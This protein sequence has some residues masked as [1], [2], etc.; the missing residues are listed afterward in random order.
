M[1][2]VVGA[3]GSLGRRIVRGL[4]ERGEA[5]RALVR[6][7]AAR[8]LFDREGARPVVGDLRDPDSLARACRAVAAVVTTASVSK[9]GSDS[10]ENVDVEGNRH[11]IAAA[12]AAGVRQFVFVST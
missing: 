2:L 12:K 4:L 5:V 3:S 8:E 11:L 6:S 10:I 1:I 7:E 9:T